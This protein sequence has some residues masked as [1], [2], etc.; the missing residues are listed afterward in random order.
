MNLCIDVWKLDLDEN[1]FRIFDSK[2]LIAGYFDPDYGQMPSGKEDEIISQM[3]KNKETVPGG[4]LMVPL[5]KFGLFDT[6]LET[7]IEELESKIVLVQSRIQK[8]KEF[9]KNTN[10]QI[11]SIRISHTE[12]D[13]LTITFPMKFSKPTSLENKELVKELEPTL[14]SLQQLGLL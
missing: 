12:Q 14:D 11:H 6:D 2:K 4:L 3:I 9:L 10:N 1:Y 7:D 5:L 8:W 13:M